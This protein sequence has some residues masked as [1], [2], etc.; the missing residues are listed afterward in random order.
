MMTRI[1]WGALALTLTMAGAEAPSPEARAW[2]RHI[3][4]LASDKL[5]GR[6]AG[7]PGHKLAADYVAAR[8]KKA[9]LA[10]CGDAGAGYLQ[11]VPLV[12]KSLIESES[13]LTA[14]TAD[15]Q[16]R[17]LVMGD[18]AILSTRAE[19]P[20]AIEAQAVFLGYGLSIPAENGGQGYDDFAGQDVRGKI[21]V[22]ISGS[23][24]HLPGAL[25]AHFSSAAERGKALAS[26]GAVGVLAIANP[27][28]SDVPWARSSAARL[29]PSMAIDDPALSG[30]RIPT[31]DAALNAAKVAW[32]FDGAAHSLASLLELS[33]KG[34]PM[35][36]FPLNVTFRGRSK[37]EK[38]KLASENV[39]GVIPGTGRGSE[40]LVLSAHLDHLGLDP[41]ARGA[42]KI[43]NGAMDNASGIATLIETARAI[44]RSGRRPARS[45]VFV[46][47]TAEEKGLLGSRYFVNRLPAQTGV[48][49]ANI[50][51]DMFLPI[52]AMRKVMAF[53]MEEST[54]RQP[55]E[56][57]TARLGLGLQ[58]D[59][60]PHRNRFIRS[61]QYS[62]IQRGVPAL[63]LKVG[64][65]P[66]S[67]EADLQ[68]QWT[69][70]RYHAL[71]DDLS[72]PVDLQAA[73]TFNRMVREL[74]VAVANAPKR[75][76][77]NQTS[78]FLRFAAPGAA[79]EITSGGRD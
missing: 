37:L 17:T 32:L 31:F 34:R 43:Y 52:H 24:E 55:L 39:C 40:L 62:F 67:P 46:A 27:K 66:G 60:E 30:N 61:D 4:Y 47:V 75:P 33:T 7:S 68:K 26:S 54:L 29:L 64:Y 25:R 79:A 3:E 42:D 38:T 19:L 77:W 22:T 57:V 15:G 13:S 12:N 59:L 5:G 78:F 48:V 74:A 72:Q 8:F 18:D 56:E 63:T 45:V 73:V 1:T 14:L 49:V 11:R 9:G 76:V 44:K 23:P 6:S 36:R 2:W 10:P 28:T 69:A 16:A 71:A 20:E 21:L 50:N 58:P 65:E 41:N 35:P 70:N 51:F 53:G